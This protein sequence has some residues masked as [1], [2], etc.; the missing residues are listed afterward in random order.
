MIVL[1]TTRYR[2]EVRP[3]CPARGCS[4]VMVATDERYRA[5]N[6]DGFTHVC[7]NWDC[8]GRAWVSEDERTAARVILEPPNPE[9]LRLRA[10]CRD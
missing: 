9:A 3:L 4:C 8:W 6:P 1:R 7:G 10:A 2:G 5:A